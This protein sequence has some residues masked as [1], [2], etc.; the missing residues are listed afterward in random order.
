M[1]LR[2]CKC[3]ATPTITRQTTGNVYLTQVICRCGAHGA[4][5]M[6]TKPEDTARMR[7]AAA[8]GWNMAD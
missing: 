1:I 5:L 7:Q 2:P 4:M 6:H 8:D 3:G